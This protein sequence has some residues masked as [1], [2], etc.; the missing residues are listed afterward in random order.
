MA[1]RLFTRLLRPASI[2][3]RALGPSDQIA[4]IFTISYDC[5][6]TRRTHRDVIVHRRGPCRLIA[7]A[8]RDNLSGYIGLF[9]LTWQVKIN[10][11]SISITFRYDMRKRLS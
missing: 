6:I 1:R 7:A 3:Q 8:L 11:C 9:G 4:P 5:T 10:A 2:M